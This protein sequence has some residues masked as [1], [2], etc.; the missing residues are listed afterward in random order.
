VEHCGF[1]V[2]ELE[3]LALNAVRYSLL[4]ADEKQALLK[5]FEQEYAE[6]RVAHI[7]EQAT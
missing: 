5:T 2:D 4:P 1:S 3:E 6:L 7:V